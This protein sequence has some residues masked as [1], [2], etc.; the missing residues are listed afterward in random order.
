[1]AENFGGALSVAADDDAVGEKKVSDGGAFA[2]ELRV[3]SDIEGFGIS[4]VAQNDFAN[5][6][7]GIDRDR[8]LLDDDFVSV[9]GAGDFAGDGLD[10]RKI[11]LAAFGWRSADGDENGGAGAH[12]FLQIVRESKALAAVTAQ[13]FGQKIFVDRD[14]PIF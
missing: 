5:P 13:Q 14:L 12:G 3:G 11:G 7:A 6:L 1:M 9:D 4:A 8:A 2:Q 10:V